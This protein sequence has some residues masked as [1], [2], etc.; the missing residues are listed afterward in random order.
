MRCAALP[1]K[2]PWR[3][4]ARA[5]LSLRWRPIR[6]GMAMSKHLERGPTAKLRGSEAPYLHILTHFHYPD[7]HESPITRQK[8]LAGPSYTCTLH[9]TPLAETRQW[10]VTLQSQH[11][12]YVA[13]I[14][15]SWKHLAR[16][17]P[18]IDGDADCLPRQ[19]LT[20]FTSPII[21]H[22]RAKENPDLPPPTQH[23]PS[24]RTQP[25]TPSHPPGHPTLTT[26]S[27][28]PTH[29]SR[30]AA[31]TSAPSASIATELWTK[32]YT[33][34][35]FSPTGTC[36]DETTRRQNRG[37]VGSRFRDRGRRPGARV[38][39]GTRLLR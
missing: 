35:T 32:C 24:K 26:T 17:L 37:V 14:L 1:E 19:A 27:N 12:P 20:P 36:A 38:S 15:Q 21:N 13:L 3:Q 22:P 31:A 4:A 33:S 30:A 10:T 5:F 11:A 2:S 28:S 23:H 6:L 18:N 8:P 29:P 39:C 9:D 16:A 25:P 34:C 7:N